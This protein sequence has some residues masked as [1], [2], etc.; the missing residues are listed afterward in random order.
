M[1]SPV[2]RYRHFIIASIRGELKG[3]YARSR[4]GL[5]WT[6]LNPLAQATIFAVILS[7]VLGARLG[8]VNVKGAYPIYLM[9]GMAAWGLFSEILNRCLSVFI[10]YAGTLKKI[11]F[12]RLCLPVIV[13][14][15]ALVNHVLLLLAMAVVF[16]FFNHF[17][18]WTWLSVLPGIMLIS[19]FAFGLGMLLGIF[20]VFARDIGQVVGVLLQIWFWLTPIVYMRDVVPPRLRWLL[21]FN[22]MVALTG[23][24]QDALLFNRWPEPATLAIPAVVALALFALSFVIFQ[25]ASAELVD[26]L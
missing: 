24:Y 3:R 20:N 13:W 6:I 22:P 15:G 2:W 7:E 17:P 23:I 21:D 25:R 10:E 14:G 12:P 16:A 26:V 11:S 19:M 5:L 4:L 9:S 1:L 8:G 18:G